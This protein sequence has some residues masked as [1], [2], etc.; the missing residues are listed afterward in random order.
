MRIDYNLTIKHNPKITTQ[1][2]RSFSSLKL[3]LQ[4]TTKRSSRDLGEEVYS[5]RFGRREERNSICRAVA[6]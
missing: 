1:Y 2:C 4:V 3:K 6:M 5:W